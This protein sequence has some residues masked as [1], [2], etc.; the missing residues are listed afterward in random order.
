MEEYLL[1]L[2]FLVS[3]ATSVSSLDDLFIDLIAIGIVRSRLPSL[4]AGAEVP[5]TGIFVANWHEEDIL[6][7]MVEGNLGRIPIPNVRIYLG[8][9]PND[10]ATRAVAEALAVKHPERVRVIV[11][12]LSGPTSKGQ[13]L[14]EMFRQVFADSENAPE[15]VVL[16]DSEDVIDPRSFEL[17]ALYANDYDF[18]QVPVFSFESRQRSLVAATYMDEFAERHTRELVVRDAVGAM[19]PSAGVGT[20]LTKRL[21]SHF[22]KMRGQVLMTGCVTEDYIIGVEAKRAGFRAA[23]AAISETAKTGR[24]FVATREFFPKDFSASIR[25]KTRWVY[26]INFEALQKLGWKG[27]GWDRYFFLRDRKG[28][29]TSFLPLVSLIL[30]AFIVA[31]IT[32]LEEMP[33]DIEPLFGASMTI[34]LAA[35]VL[36]FIFRSAALKQVYGSFDALGVA[37][38]WPVAVVVNAIATFRAW[39]I[40]LVES[41]FA[42]RPIAWAKTEHELPDQFPGAPRPA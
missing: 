19:I 2:T 12:S 40:F 7:K 34:N 17:Y 3:L 27:D 10:T 35:L 37:L 30:L 15:F 39:R 28:M 26:G 25:Q 42:T 4:S 6:E 13:M 22:V 18:I 21:I 23:F 32:H 5:T 9:Y 36:R 29:I 41:G 38:R 31:G 33:Q 8:I 16:H 20:C 24:D 14:N 11:N 1:I